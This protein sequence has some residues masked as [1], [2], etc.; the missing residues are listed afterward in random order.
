MLHV[1]GPLC[2]IS[3]IIPAFAIGHYQCDIQLRVT[4][5]L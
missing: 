5:Q 2:L 4:D 1:M 3:D